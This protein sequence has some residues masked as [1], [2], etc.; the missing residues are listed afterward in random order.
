MPV[1]V[2]DDD[3]VIGEGTAVMLQELQMHAEW[4]LSGQEAVQMVTRRHE[5]GQDYFA[6]LI[7]WKM[8]GMDG[9][10][11]AQAIRQAVGNA[12]KLVL[13]SAYDLS[14]LSLDAHTVG[15]DKFITKP[16]FK[17]RLVGVCR[18]LLHTEQAVDVGEM[19]AAHTD[20]FSGRRV[21]L[22]ED[23]ELNAE[24]AKELLEM[25]GVQVEWVENGEI[26]VKWMES[27]RRRLL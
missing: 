10:Q 1:L 5:E 27:G 9:I 24:I 8:P 25:S 2:V 13:V 23:N 12:V 19:L 6:V 14:D 20:D 15:I 17:S 3:P 26:A 16:L 11:T 21:L 18:E 4:C 7:D 22:V